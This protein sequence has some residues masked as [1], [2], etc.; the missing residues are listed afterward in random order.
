MTGA[1]FAQDKNKAIDNGY[2]AAQKYSARGFA[3]DPGPSSFCS[4][5]SNAVFQVNMAPGV[6]NLFII[7]TDDVRNMRLYV[8]DE[9][10]QIIEQNSTGRERARAVRF[11]SRYAG[12]AYVYAFFD[13]VLGMG[14]WASL[15]CSRPLNP[16]PTISSSQ[17]TNDPFSA[18]VVNKSFN[19][20]SVPNNIPAPSTPAVVGTRSEN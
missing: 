4:A 15:I 11:N 13:D 16:A 18:G 12:V 8:V 20:P 10:G 2:L 19:S 6:E 3:V 7:A 14:A 1:V 17:M 9:F 5:G